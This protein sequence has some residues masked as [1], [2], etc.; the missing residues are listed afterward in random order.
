[1]RSPVTFLILLLC[2]F[3]S[4]CLVDD[5][6][7]QP[8]DQSGKPDD[9]VDGRYFYVSGRIV[10]GV[11]DGAKV[12]VYPIGGG[13][14]SLESVAESATAPDG[15]YQ[16]RIPREYIGKSALIRATTAGA[17]MKCDLI[18]GCGQQNFDDW[19]LLEGEGPVIDI[20][21]PELREGGIYNGSVLTHLG[22]AAAE[23]RLPEVD[24]SSNGIADTTAKLTLSKANSEV[25]STFGVI[26]DLPSVKIVD[27]T[28][29]EDRAS[30][31]SSEL[32]YSLINSVAVTTASDVYGEPNFVQ[33][34]TKLTAQ[35]VESGI[36]GNSTLGAEEV[37][38]SSLLAALADA[39]RYF[40]GLDGNK[41][42]E[43]QSEIL[44]L[45]GL[46]L[47]EP[48]HEYGRGVS[49]DSFHLTFIEKAK[50]MVRGVRD[51]AL[52]LDLRRLVDINNLSGLL[53]GDV[54]GALGAFGVVVDTSLVLKDEKVDQVQSALGMVSEGVLD[55]LLSY[56]QKSAQ[57]QL[58]QG[59]N[60]IHLPESNSHRF[61]IRGSVDA[62]GDAGAGSNACE[63]PV[64]LVLFLE[65][66]S[67]GGNTS[68]ASIRIDGLRA[69]LLGAV[70]DAAYRLN[71]SGTGP[72]FIAGVLFLE[73][74]SDVSLSRT[75]VEVQDW[76]MSLPVSVVARDED[77]QSSL[78][79]T[80]QSTGEELVMRFESQEISIYESDSVEEFVSNQL[81]E[82][83]HLKRFN[84]NT[85]FSVD[86][87]G[88]DRFLAAID[89]TQGIIPFE[90]K[91]VYRM[92]SRRAC[93][94]EHNGCVVLE[95]ESGIEGEA[96]DNF[97][98][99]SASVAYKANL[100]AIETPVM[101]QMSGSR[102]SPATN[103]VSSLKVSYPGNALALN[104]R[105][106]NSGGI[107]ALDAVNLDGMRLNFDTIN[108]KRTGKVE[109]PTQETV[110]DIID[111]GQWVKVR[112]ID[113]YFE[114]LL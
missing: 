6:K 18:T 37:A 101:I 61:V 99:M 70:G 100:K 14:R 84:L 59:L 21:V 75:F 46:Y 81:Y 93:G 85:A 103:K 83:S 86:V 31:T 102:E 92:S 16:L 53:S 47:N 35:F 78:N 108:G 13:L 33:A 28:D 71:F 42:S 112:Y 64:D 25:A 8:N 57:P 41:Y 74:E 56:Y 11:F 12:R 10:K 68:V 4:G 73:D 34:L 51:I 66:D 50:L 106:N 19:V 58:A 110:A 114:S 52:S 1:M 91:A 105:F 7:G 2:S 104:G 30:A 62:C 111:M 27:V 90:G 107:I 23:A 65:F 3:L 5:L 96:A 89:F 63:V 26:G 87:T 69:T 15:S 55:T 38:Q 98:R 67:F 94:P 109:T 39:Y 97:V 49:S 20:G 79:G 76:W 72:Q 44:A 43:I 60:I 24:V 113:G 54:S 95:D 82:L 36:P 80:L 9:G 17:R 22:F 29:P 77:S 48:L 40:D 45:R 32:H 88:E